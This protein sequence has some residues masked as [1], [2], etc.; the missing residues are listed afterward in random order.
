MESLQTERF[1]MKTGI[2]RHS[3]QERVLYGTAA[4]DG[5]LQEAERLGARRIFLITSNSLA[6]QTD[7]I[8]KISNALGERVA[9]HFH[10]VPQHPTRDVVM[11]AIR[12]VCIKPVCYWD[13]APT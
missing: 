9:L 2:Y 7:E 4:A 8:R 1:E 13:I 3:L 10:R 6:T 5:F 11:N 12:P